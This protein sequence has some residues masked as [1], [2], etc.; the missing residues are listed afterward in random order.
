MLFLVLVLLLGIII[1]R[2]RNEMK[3]NNH[4]I[5][6]YSYDDIEF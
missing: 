6:Y 5:K 2:D 1:I 3:K 4:N